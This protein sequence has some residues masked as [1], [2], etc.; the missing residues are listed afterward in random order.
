MKNANKKKIVQDL[1]GTEGA[2]TLVNADHCVGGVYILLDDVGTP[3]YVGE[4]SK[5]EARITAHGDKQWHS[6]L[7]IPVQSG[8]K[9]LRRQIETALI[10]LLRPLYNGGGSY[11]ALTSYERNT[12]VLLGII[13]RQ[14]TIWDPHIY[15]IPKWRHQELLDL[16]AAQRAAQAET[17]RQARLEAYHL[18]PTPYGGPPLLDTDN[19]PQI[20]ISEHVLRRAYAPEMMVEWASR[21]K[22]CRGAIEPDQVYFYKHPSF[23]ERRGGDING[24]DYYAGGVWC[25]LKVGDYFES[26]GLY[27]H[28]PPKIVI[29]NGIILRS[30]LESTIQ[31]EY[32]ES[33]VRRDVH[34]GRFEDGSFTPC[35]PPEY[36]QETDAEKQVLRAAVA[37]FEQGRNTEISNSREVK[38]DEH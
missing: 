34:M 12:E 26:K 32:I 38:Q 8:D 11:A 28:I 37:L 1:A 17:R 14:F 23:E 24:A 19:K 10:F 4:S 20:T 29:I 3:V 6:A 35:S 33:G 22:H 16:D 7:C 27:P 31:V 13:R 30:D 15:P 21:L 9:Y 36:S 2:F 5:I 25:L 18:F